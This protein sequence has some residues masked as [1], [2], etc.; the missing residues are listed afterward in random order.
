MRPHELTYALLNP[1][2]GSDKDALG[3]FALQTDAEGYLS[4][5]L[6]IHTDRLIAEK[7]I[8]WNHNEELAH[9][10]SLRKKRAL[11]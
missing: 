1:V 9:P 5:H 4:V 3:P 2:I 6:N 11:P 8:H 10:A 7:T